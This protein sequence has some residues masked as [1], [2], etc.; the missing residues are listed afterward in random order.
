MTLQDEKVQ[1]PKP[2]TQ[3]RVLDI[4]LFFFSRSHTT[5][6]ITITRVERKPCN[7]GYSYYT[8]PKKKDPS[9]DRKQAHPKT[10]K[11]QEE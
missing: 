3:V 11:G 4:I 8:R 7:Y 9:K 1:N 2:K 5:K 10:N 6:L